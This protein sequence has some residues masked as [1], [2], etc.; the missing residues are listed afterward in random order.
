LACCFVAVSPL[1]AAG[2]QQADSNLA[3]RKLMIKVVAGMKVNSK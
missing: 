2:K 1:S 3:R